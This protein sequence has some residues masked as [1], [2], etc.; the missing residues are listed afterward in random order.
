MLELRNPLRLLR[1]ELAR[2][3]L[4]RTCAL[5]TA[6]DTLLLLG[7]CLFGRITLEM[8]LFVGFFNVAAWYFGA[9][10][11]AAFRT[12]ADTGKESANLTLAR[13]VVRGANLVLAA[14]QVLFTAIVLAAW[15]R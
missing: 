13:F 3:R 8:G 2:S 5:V 15:T 7:A 10:F 4:V 11:P 14:I 12:F 9:V 1:S 6:M